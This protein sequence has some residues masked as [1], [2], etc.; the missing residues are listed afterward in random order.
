VIIP[1]YNRS[2]LL[3][4]T[5]DSLL[6]Q[7]L[8][9]KQIEV[10]IADDGSSDDTFAVAQ[11]Y[12]GKLN[13]K[14][15]YQEDKGYRVASARNLGIRLAQGEVLVFVDSG[16]ILS[17]QFLSTHLKAHREA[18]VPLAVIGYVYCFDHT[19][20]FDHHRV[21][22]RKPRKTI[23]YFR[24]QGAQLDIREDCYRKY[25]DQL[26]TLPAPWTFFWG[27]NISVR[28]DVVLQ[29][30]GFDENFDQTWGSEDIEFGYRLHQQNVKFVLEREAEAIHYPHERHLDE[31]FKK[32]I[33]NKRYFH[34]KYN[35]PVTKLFLRSHVLRLNDDLLEYQRRQAKHAGKAGRPP[36]P[37]NQQPEPAF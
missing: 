24:S 5:L 9:R 19:Q 1:T 8:N 14:Y 30:G 29:A 16:M 18:A 27:G 6:K 23:Q 22:P 37:V 20:A 21:D 32:E 3:R 33:I 26:A 12:T 11:Q 35:S 13:L 2:E 17:G 34:K 25:N 15:V 7:N 28:R 36:V 4:Y 10:I 31:R